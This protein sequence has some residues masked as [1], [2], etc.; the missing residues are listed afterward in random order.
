MNGCKIYVRFG[1]DIEGYPR[2]LAF[3]GVGAFKPC[4][5]TVLCTESWQGLDINVIAQCDR[6]TLSFSKL[7]CAHQARVS[8]L[9]I[10][11]QA[12]GD[13]PPAKMSPFSEMSG[14]VTNT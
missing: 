8:P 1:D 5:S 3:R 2:D 13:W 10:M 6:S 4:S 11:V 7:G 14:T 9:W 12:Q